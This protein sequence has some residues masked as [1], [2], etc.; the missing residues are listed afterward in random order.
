[1]NGRTDW[2]RERVLPQ[3]N[4]WKNTR[5]GQEGR[6]HVRESI[7][8]RAVKQAVR[9]ARVV[10]HVG[11]H[12]FRH[13]LGTGLLESGFGIRTIQELL[14]HKDVTMTIV[15]THVLNKREHGVRNPM[16]GL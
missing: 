2:R 4:R 3:E 16:H 11:C 6:H 7:P 5:I 13:S 15:C 14:G 1:M 9:R 12:T 8:Q 10:K